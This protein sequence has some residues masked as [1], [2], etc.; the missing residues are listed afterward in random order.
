MTSRRIRKLHINAPDETLVRRGEIL[1]ED[2]FHTAA[3]PNPGGRLLIVRSLSLGVIRSNQSPA[4]VARAIEERLR[5][6]GSS[7]VYAEDPSAPWRP[8]IYFHN[9]A[10]P[11]IR[12]AIRLASG[13]N[14]DAW[15]WPLAVA[16]FRSG[17][18]PD[19][20]LRSLLFE[21]PKTEAGIAMAA[22]IV[23]ALIERDA[24]DRL[25]ETLRWQDGQVLLKAAGCSMPQVPV[26]LRD[27]ESSQTSPEVEI[28]VRW[29]AALDRWTSRWGA[30]DA[31][32][33]WLAALALIAEI[34]ARA[35]DPRLA[36]RAAQLIALVTRRRASIGPNAVRTATNDSPVASANPNRPFSTEEVSRSA[37]EADRPA[38]IEARAVGTQS[39]PGRSKV[40]GDGWGN[41]YVEARAVGTLSAPR[42]SKVD[43]DGWSNSHVESRGGGTPTPQPSLTAPSDHTEAPRFTR[44][45]GMLLLLP[46]LSRLG[47]ATLL[48]CNPLL[49]E[50][51]LP[52]R[53]LLHVGARLEIAPDDPMMQAL[54]GLCSKN[55]PAI[56]EFVE[57]ELWKQGIHNDGPLQLRRVEGSSRERVLFD[58]SGRL[59][60]ALWRGEIP[61]AVRLLARDLPVTRGPSIEPQNDL[62][63]LLDSWLV[64]MRRWCRR[65]ARVGLRDLVCR[66]GRVSATSTHVDA[67]FDHRQADIRVRKAGLDL[68]P[69]WIPWFGRVVSFH[70]Q[71]GEYADG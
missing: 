71:Y 62:D 66:P 4:A 14:T 58:G 37:A 28:P 52:L 49:I 43:G 5:L 13:H 45:A 48:E 64:A 11:Y 68:D 40:D 16:P 61:I 7:A 26:T 34:S 18:A 31:R 29:L 36:I 35:L 25:F 41:P 38:S 17:M 60:L 33:V 53:L 32:T 47:I 10:E 69:G 22:A 23:R 42:R 19:E 21:A 20:A 9:E 46:V 8:V 56:G 6:L 55:P 63:L 27:A 24:A 50:C 12:L 67:V 65:Y 3:L 1:L 39:A 2:A 57:P 59:S 70:Y 30:D 15:F 51:A 54:G 44:Y